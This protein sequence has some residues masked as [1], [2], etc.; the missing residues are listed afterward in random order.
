MPRPCRHSS[1]R[2]RTTRV[3]GGHAFGARK[4]IS[5][6]LPGRGHRRMRHCGQKAPGFLCTAGA[7]FCVLF[8]P[9]SRRIPLCVSVPGLVLFTARCHRKSG[10]PPR[11]T[12]KWSLASGL[13]FLRLFCK[14]AFRMKKSLTRRGG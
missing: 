4:E 5:P 12:A 10:T 14:D 2:A 6:R 8:A 3:R 7:I 1:S 9:D 11:W 13:N